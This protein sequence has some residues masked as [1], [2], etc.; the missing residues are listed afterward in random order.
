M[1]MNGSKMGLVLLL[2][3]S[4]TSGVLLA[5]PGDFNIDGVYE[6]ALDLP[7]IYFL[8]KR[9]PNGPPLEYMGSFELNYGFLDTGA[10][11]ILMSLETAEAMELVIEPDAEFVDVG[12]AGEEYFDVSEPLYFGTADFAAPDPYDPDIYILSGPWR[13]QIRQDYAELF[14]VD[15]IGIPVMAGKTVVLDPSGTNYLDYFY[16]DIKLAD[17]PTI[18]AVDFKVALRFEKY[19]FPEDPRNI[20][21]LPV[22]AYNP[23]IDGIV[24]EYGDI[25]LTGSWLFDTGAVISNMSVAQGVALG[26][27]DEYGEPI[28]T[29]DFYIDVGGIGGIVTLPGFQ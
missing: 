2:L 4:I 19:I 16:A 14:P 11:G 6:V 25:N 26:L 21:P 3:L 12:V 20:P 24:V 9:E 28:V 27:T 15:V 5:G 1:S 29:P 17:D 22:L 18:P 13:L 23:V 10:S 8:F 7:R